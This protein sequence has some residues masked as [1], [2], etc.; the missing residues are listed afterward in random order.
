M[1]YIFSDKSPFLTAHCALEFGWGFLYTS[2]ESVN[3]FDSLEPFYLKE[4]V[5]NTP[6]IM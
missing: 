5:N 3:D 1:L 6:S 2:S 4:T